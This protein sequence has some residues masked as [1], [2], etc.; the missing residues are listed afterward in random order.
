M[1]EIALGNLIRVARCGDTTSAKS[2][3]CVTK[4]IRTVVYIFVE[5]DILARL[6]VT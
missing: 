5:V 4:T 2:F 6:R 3:L 1:V